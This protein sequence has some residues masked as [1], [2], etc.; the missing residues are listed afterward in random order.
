MNEFP[1]PVF[2]AQLKRNFSAF[3]FDKISFRGCIHY[4]NV[5]KNGYLHYIRVLELTIIV[6]SLVDVTMDIPFVDQILFHQ[7]LIE[8]A[9]LQKRT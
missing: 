5:P 1:D 8:C 7:A 3:F 2:P 9:I 4:K 6:A